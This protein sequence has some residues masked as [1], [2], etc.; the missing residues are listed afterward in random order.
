MRQEGY[1]WVK[2]NH[3]WIVCEWDGYRWWAPGV[4]DY[5]KD[6]D[7]EEINENRLVYDTNTNR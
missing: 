3:Y 2:D 7:F 5:F 6:S 4:E 1:Y